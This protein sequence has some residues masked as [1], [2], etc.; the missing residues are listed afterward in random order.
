MPATNQ[1]EDDLLDL[2][3]NN[4]DSQD[5]GDAPGLQASAAPGSTELSLSIAPG[6]GETDTSAT[7]N[8]VAYTGY[9]RPTQLRTTAGW[10]ISGTAPTQASN[11]ALEQ[12]G[13]MTA[14]G[15]DTVTDFGLQ[16][17]DANLSNYLQ[18]YGVLDA[19]LIIND[20]VNPQ[21]AVGALDI[22]LV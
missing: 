3:F 22:T 4:I 8:E 21:F 2:I 15:P 17:F 11:A 7:T 5:I 16:L 12:F 9:V 20:G 1:F 10:T 14:L 6:L 18:I 19:P 13:E